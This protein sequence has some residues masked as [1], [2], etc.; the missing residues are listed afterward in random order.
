[1]LMNTKLNLKTNFFCEKK[2]R[3]KISKISSISAMF[4]EL[5]API[6]LKR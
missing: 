3:I 6:L 5:Q 2:K 4:F 1:M